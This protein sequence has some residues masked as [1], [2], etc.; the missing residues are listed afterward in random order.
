MESSEHMVD[1]PRFFAEA[2]RVLAPGGRFVIL[3]VARRGG[4]RL[5][6]PT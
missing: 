5:R 2:H 1:K 3:R 6:C 4:R